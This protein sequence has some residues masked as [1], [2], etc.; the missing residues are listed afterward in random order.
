MSY[1]QWFDAHE[2][3]HRAIIKK[4]QAKAYTKEQM[5][6]YFDFE[7]MVQKEPGF[8]PLFAKK[9]KCHDIASLNCYL[10]ACPHFRFSEQ[11]IKKEAKGMRFSLCAIEAK[12]GAVFKSE[13]AL[14]Q[15][16]SACKLPHQRAFIDKVFHQ[17]WFEIMKP[18]DLT[19]PVKDG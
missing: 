7:N 17:S 2:A 15:D 1:R 18:C 8:C 12:Q 4:L 11:G 13:G 16:C 14:H 19:K 6:S 10:C 5:I 9:Q 3:R